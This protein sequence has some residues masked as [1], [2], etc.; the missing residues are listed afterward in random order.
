MNNK[1]EG[2]IPSDEL[3][4]KKNIINNASYPQ[5]QLWFLDLIYQE[6]SAYN[7]PLVFKVKGLFHYDVFLNAINKIIKRHSTFRTTFEMSDGMPKQ[8]IHPEYHISIPI[9]DL[10]EEIS[11]EEKLEK[12]IKQIISKTFN[13]SKGPLFTSNIFKIAEDD[14]IILM[15]FHNIIVDESSL[16]IFQKEL[17][18]YYN[19]YLNNIKDELPKTDWIPENEQSNNEEKL[20]YWKKQLNGNIPVLNLPNDYPR[21]KRQ[22]LKGKEVKV[23]V[24]KELTEKFKTIWSNGNTSYVIAFLSAFEILMHRLSGQNEIITGYTFP[25]RVHQNSF[26]Y[27]GNI[28]NT[29]PLRVNLKDELTFND[30]ASVTKDIYYNAENNQ[31]ISFEQIVDELQP[32]RDASYNP[33]F[34]IDFSYQQQASNLNFDKATVSLLYYHNDTSKFDL[35][36]NLID[37]TVGV[38]CLLEYSEDLFNESTAKRFLRYY[39]QLLKSIVENPNKKISELKIIPANEEDLLLNI[40]NNTE[41]EYP[42]KVLIELI[43]EQVKIF[44]GKVAVAFERK[45]LTYDELNKKANKLA[46]YLVHHGVKKDSL[47]GL[48]V[49]RSLE[50]MVCLLAIQKAGGAYIPLDPAFPHDRLVYMTQDS[51]LK[52]LITQ[53]KYIDIFKE[54]NLDFIKIEDIDKLTESFSNEDLNLKYDVDSLAYIIYTSGSTGKPKG[55]Q[56]QQRAL[57]NFLWSMQNEPGIKETDVLVS[58]TTLSF[59]IAGLELY[60]PLLIGAKVVIVSKETSMD[61]K[62]L[63]HSLK[64]FNATIMQATPAAWRMLLETGWK[65]EEKI[66]MLCGGEALPRDLADKLSSTGG[67]LWNMYGPTETTIW[68]TIKLIKSDEDKITI[69][70]PINN[71]QIYILYNNLQPVPIGVK[72]DLFIGGDGLAKGYF[73]NQSLTNEKFIDNP[74]LPGKKIYKTGDLA[75]YLPDGRIEHLGRSDFQVKIRGFRIE[76]EEIEVQL[77]R[78]DKVKEA[79]VVARDDLSGHQSLCAYVISKEGIDCTISNIKNHLKNSLPD[80]MIPTSYSF[81]QE[82]PLTPNGK[83]DRKALIKMEKSFDEEVKTLI[84]AKDEIEKQLL[85]IWEG[86]LNNKSIS[87]TDNFFEIG[88]HSLLAATMFA[89]IEEVMKI[90]LPLAVLFTSST[91]QK[92]A[93]VIRKKDYTNLWSSLVP[94]QPDGSKIPLFL[95]HGAEGNVLLYREL[96]QYLGPDQPVYGLQSQGL[97]GLKDFNPKFEEVASFYIKEIKKLQPEGPYLLGGYCLGGTIAYEMAQ[98]LKDKGEKVALL[99]MLE[100]YNIQANPEALKFPIKYLHKVQNVFFHLNNFLRAS[101]KARMEFVKQK[102]ETTK[103]RLKVRYE[104]LVAKITNNKELE[105]KYPHLLVQKINDLAQEKYNPKAYNGNITLFKPTMDFVGFNDPYYGWKNLVPKIE[106]HPLK[107]SPRGML[108]EPF[109]Q[110]LAQKLKIEI[111]EALKNNEMNVV[112][113]NN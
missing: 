77:N 104:N 29:L 80:Y 110:E 38:E 9:I 42:Q 12:E 105:D 108:V 91:I 37:T 17:S 55:V 109:V 10:S 98:Q 4:D 3:K 94:I 57:V 106:V 16:I 21:P 58:V 95:V 47:V 107:I 81:I 28:A 14:N 22:S 75:K 40:W 76:L 78:Y 64:H 46:K 2:I 90:K 48:S 59:D 60:L 83:V 36:L 86:L 5:R 89:K 50:M 34:Q 26:N 27:I 112:A 23:I 71:T 15:N 8:I 61:G 97:D 87:I 84:E 72:G 93:E 113:I 54:E 73:N 92:L 62:L 69:G 52:V 20:N 67:E 6:N 100:T 19:N 25:N 103:F 24:D 63:K 74:F 79:V 1:T 33:L 85:G 35:S 96:S 45:H 18:F 102:S 82:F 51:G 88:G 70:R 13:L 43:E 39:L 53:N 68:S 99:A 56:I 41:I 44:P 101:S 32:I 11:K 30:L 7:I 49:D 66:K 31:E 111:E 65:N